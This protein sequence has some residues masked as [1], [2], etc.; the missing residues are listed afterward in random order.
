MP[1]IESV[2]RA[3][4]HGQLGIHIQISGQARRAQRDLRPLGTHL[5]PAR[6]HVAFAVDVQIGGH[7]AVTRHEEQALSRKVVIVG[8]K[9]GNLGI[10]MW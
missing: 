5:H 8:L 10:L 9:I 7:A 6:A 4:G 2:P 1:E 3:F